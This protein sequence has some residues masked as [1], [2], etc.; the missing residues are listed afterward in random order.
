M[1]LVMQAKCGALVPAK[2][3]LHRLS[4]ASRRR[5]LAGI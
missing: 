2:L 5:C 3:G 4:V 1:T